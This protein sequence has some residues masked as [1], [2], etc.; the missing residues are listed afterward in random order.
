MVNCT[1][2][3]N[4]LENWVQLKQI[5]KLQ[6]RISQLDLHLL[7]SLFEILNE[8]SKLIHLD[9]IVFRLYP[10]DILIHDQIIPHDIHYIEILKIESIP[11][12]IL[13]DLIF[14]KNYPSLRNLELNS[15][16]NLSLFNSFLDRHQQLVKIHLTIPLRPFKTEESKKLSKSLSFLPSLE[17]LSLSFIVSLMEKPSLKTTKIVRSLHQ[18]DSLDFIQIVFLT[19]T[20]EHNLVF[21][22]PP[23]KIVNIVNQYPVTY[24]FS[25]NDFQNDQPSYFIYFN[26]IFNFKN[27][28]I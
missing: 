20:K 16:I 3:E 2:V 24:N 19:Q 15:E 28:I 4:L 25:K 17:Y 7:N 1:H 10:L 23:F 14:L 18:S 11:F 8:K 12:N 21:P 22:S 5:E 27:K 6:L 9:I 26:K 13:R